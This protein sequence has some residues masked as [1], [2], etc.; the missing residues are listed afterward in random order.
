MYAAR[1]RREAVAALAVAGVT[2]E[3]AIALGAVDQ[4]AV[5]HLAP[6]A[7]ELAAVLAML[8]PRIVVTHPLEGGHPD[9]DAAALVTAA[10]LSLL[11]REGHPVPSAFEMTSYHRGAAGLETGRFLP[12]GSQGV[13][14]VLTPGER[15]AKR[16]MLDAYGSQREVLAPFRVDVERFRPAVAPSLAAPPHPGPLHYET[17][18]WTT[19]EAFREAAHEG[20]VALGLSGEEDRPPG[21]PPP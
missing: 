15:I 6:L 7:R 10:A 5:R 1:R 21:A 4:E 20:L 19:F 13:T 11:A 17:L 12:G 2:A 18:G 3:D 16:T 8:S 9:H 14:H